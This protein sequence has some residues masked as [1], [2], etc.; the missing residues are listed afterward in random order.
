[1][2]ATTRSPSEPEQIDDQMMLER[3]LTH[4]LLVALVDM[5]QQRRRIH[6]SAG[7]RFADAGG[8]RVAADL[9]DVSREIDHH[10]PQQIDRQRADIPSQD[11]EAVG[12][13][14]QHAYFR[15]R[16]H[17][18]DRGAQRPQQVELPADQALLQVERP[19]Q[20][21]FFVRQASP[22]GGRPLAARVVLRPVND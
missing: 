13:R 18:R 6:F 9:G 22:A 20:F 15:R 17:R 14:V 21:G 16:R 7:D 1:M 2:G 4:G 8:G 11:G 3:Q 19:A 10:R 5:C 12:Q